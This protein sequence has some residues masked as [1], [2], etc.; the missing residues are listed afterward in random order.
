M[1][2]KIFSGE[3]CVIIA[4]ICWG[5]IGLFTRKMSDSGLNAIQI[6]F[7]RNLLASIVLFV[8]IFFCNRKCLK[9]SLK[10]I[11]M[12]VGTGIC[13][14][15]FFNICYFKAI[16]M[17]SLSVAA[18]LL[19]T[20]PVMVVVLS[21]IFLGE[22]FSIKKAVA[23]VLAFAGC[24]FTTG[25]VGTRP[26]ISGMGMLI[27]LGSGLGYAL[28]SIFGAIALKK[29]NTITITFYT[30]FMATVG[31]LPFSGTVRMIG[32]IQ[33]IPNIIPVTIC[34]AVFST[35]LPFLFYT[36]GLK[37]MEAGKASIMAFIEPMV[38]SICG[39]VIFK[40]TLAVSNIIGIVLIFASL[41]VIHRDGVT[42]SSAR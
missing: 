19:Y 18:I 13:S 36:T 2:K 5:L 1:S 7:L 34:L 27:G 40:E 9:I 22:K 41:V 23:L 17:T 29:Y 10:D 21:C 33:S 16:Q 35:V 6:T 42:G 30:F 12:F 28:Y 25:I 8:I 26:G 31:L 4:G 11:W 38:A 37:Y 39:V 20:A 3:L 24:I 15:A 14:I 32:L